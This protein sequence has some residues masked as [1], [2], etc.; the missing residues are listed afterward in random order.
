MKR[1]A[2]ELQVEK[3]FVNAT[4]LELLED[5]AC[6]LYGRGQKFVQV[7]VMKPEIKKA[8]VNTR[9]EMILHGNLSKQGRVYY[10]SSILRGLSYLVVMS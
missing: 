7:L 1:C 8:L 6:V 9:C 4:Q 5:G 10:D 2:G 3:G